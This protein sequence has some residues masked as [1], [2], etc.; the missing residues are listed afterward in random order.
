MRNR[1]S[2]QFKIREVSQQNCLRFS[3]NYSF[4]YVRP[5]AGIWIDKLLDVHM[6]THFDYNGNYST[7]NKLRKPQDNC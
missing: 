5:N 1:V 7:S 6:C 2:Y 4:R 3:I